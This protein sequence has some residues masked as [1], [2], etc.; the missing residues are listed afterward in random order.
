MDGI[1][2]GAKGHF[3]HEFAQADAFVIK[4]HG[5]GTDR[6]DRFD[7]NA[8]GLGFIVNPCDQRQM[9]A[10][11]C[12]EGNGDEGAAIYRVAQIGREKIVVCAVNGVRNVQYVHGCV[13]F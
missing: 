2:V 10:V 7:G 9:F 13:F 4:T 11:S 1:A 3:L 12:A 5:V 8:V 6:Q